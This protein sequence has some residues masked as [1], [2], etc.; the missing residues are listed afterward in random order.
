MAGMRDDFKHLQAA[1]VIA[2]LLLAIG[3]GT[4]AAMFKWTERAKQDN[5][6][7]QLAK[8]E[9]EGRLAR[10]TEEE[11]EIRLNILQYRALAEKGVIGDENRLDWIERLAAIKTARR[12]FDIH[13]EI[14]EQQRLDNSATGAEIMV[15]KMNLTVPL[16]HE[17]DLLNLLG[18][19]RAA[20]RGYFQVK[21]C[22]IARGAPVD[23]RVLAPTLSASC[24]LDFYTIR[25]RP[26]GKAAGS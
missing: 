14:S 26:A 13:Y 12:L 2:A 21:K 4:V 17:D 16:L 25:E 18:D 22:N 8:T 15:S 3:G 23:R 24:E 19:M 7:A 6:Q 5:V 10:A 20:P 9:A 1:L 11:K